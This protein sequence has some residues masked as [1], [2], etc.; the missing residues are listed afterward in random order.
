MKKRAVA[1]M[2]AIV[3]V[4]TFGPPLDAAEKF[5]RLS[6]PQ[7][8]AKLAGMETHWADVFATNG[9]LISYSMGRTSMGKWNVRRDELCIG[10]GNDEAG[11]Y[12]VWLSGKKVE[13]RREGSSLPME[14]VLQK[15]SVRR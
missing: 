4:L 3:G 6:G 10:R 15:Q 8:R 11:C 13:L 9:T 1:V 12:Q 14:G 5:Q 2:V 7:I